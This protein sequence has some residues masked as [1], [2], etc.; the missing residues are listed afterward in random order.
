MRGSLGRSVRFGHAA[1]LL[2]A[3]AYG[4]SAQSGQTL[5]DAGRRALG[6]DVYAK[7]C[8]V[9]Y[10]HGAGGSAGRAPALAGKVYESEPLRNIILNGTRSGMP[11]F[12]GVLDDA[13][14]G[15]VAAYVLSLPAPP[16][17][18]GPTPSG[19]ASQLAGAAL[20]G[21]DLFYDAE[22]MPS[23]S[24]CHEAGGKGGNVAKP[25]ARQAYT[26]AGIRGIKPVPAYRVVARGEAPMTAILVRQ[27]SSSVRLVDIS[28]PLPVVRTFAPEQIRMET[29]EWSHGAAVDRYK[30]DELE[31]L[32]Q[33]LGSF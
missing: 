23:C 25:L 15:A 26:M 17:A 33:F 10:C 8:A 20:A 11:A 27:D 29:T 16:S 9:P 22:R 5:S 30:P 6:A 1:V 28:S 21:R 14:I 31:A 12:R 24:A 4:L 3:S 19:T 7:Q 2:A 32:L 18:A 13:A